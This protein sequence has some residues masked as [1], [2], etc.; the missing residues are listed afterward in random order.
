M[1]STQQLHSMFRTD[2][3]TEMLFQISNKPFINLISIWIP[4]VHPRGN[5]IMMNRGLRVGYIQYCSGSTARFWTAWLLWGSGRVLFGYCNFLDFPSL[6]PTNWW[7]T[8]PNGGQVFQLI[9][10]S[11]SPW[12]PTQ[13]RHRFI[14]SLVAPWGSLRKHEI[15][16]PKKDKQGN[17]Y[18]LVFRSV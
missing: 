8:S 1:I 11:R 4:D 6:Y 13:L 17:S 5:H 16:P 18:C 12:Y 14:T 10:H 7:Q 9:S 2:F 3:S 15:S